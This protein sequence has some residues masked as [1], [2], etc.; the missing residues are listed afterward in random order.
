[1]TAYIALLR[2]IN[3]GGS[4]VLPMRDLSALCE[5]LGF[6]R[7]RT[8]IQS[9][10]VVFRSRRPRQD[11]L[12]ALEA[13]LAERMEKPVDVILRTA[14]ELRAALAGNPFSAHEPSR[15]LVMFLKRPA[16]EDLLQRLALP[17]AEEVRIDRQEI[18]IHYPD[19]MGRSKLKMPKDVV[20]T[21]RN[22]NTVTKLVDL[23]G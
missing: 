1:M 15:V 4:S 8:F 19:G 11:V 13:S 18:Y 14:E 12:Q 20:G 2:A 17:G 5:G 6:E 7:V 16:P 22:I 3:V 9:G 23:A 10:N 21:G